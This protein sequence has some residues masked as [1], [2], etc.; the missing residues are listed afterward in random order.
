M[1]R[2]NPTGTFHLIES[3]LAYINLAGSHMH[4][5]KYNG[6]NELDGKDGT[7]KNCS[8]LINVIRLSGKCK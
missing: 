1:R 7:R 2:H 8:L 5:L 3:K 6:I 4:L